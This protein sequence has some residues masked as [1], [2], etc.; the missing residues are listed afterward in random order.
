MA[1]NYW[2]T[3]AS[4]LPVEDPRLPHPKGYAIARLIH[5]ELSHQGLAVVLLDNWRDVGY[6]IDCIIDDAPVYL[7]FTFL[8][9]T[10]QQY[11]LCCTSDLGWISRLLGRRDDEQRLKLARAVATV[12]DNRGEFEDVRWYNEGWGGLEDEPWTNRPG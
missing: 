4:P 12:L 2:V 1:T 7:F 3:F 6:S 8:G 9:R 11:V 10:T 5:D